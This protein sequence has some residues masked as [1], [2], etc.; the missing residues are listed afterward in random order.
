MDLKCPSDYDSGKSGDLFATDRFRFPLVE[1][2]GVV[3]KLVRDI[4]SS[5]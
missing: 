1:L 4:L 3:E 2:S 5:V